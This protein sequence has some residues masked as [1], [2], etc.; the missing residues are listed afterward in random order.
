MK[1]KTERKN[2][3]FLYTCTAIYI[4]VAFIIYP[5]VIHNGLFDI[6][7]TKY[8]FYIFFSF[9]FIF[10]CLIYVVHTKN[11]KIILKVTL[12][13]IC[14]F[15]FMLINI[16]SF[17]CSSSKDISLYGS[18]G[19]MFGLMTII[20][21]CISC[22]FIS[23]LFIVSENTI[24]IICIGS[25]LV[26]LIGILNFCGIDPLQ[27]YRKMASY[28]KDVFIGTLGH[29]NIYSS[30]F[31]L[32][33]PICFVMFI[34]NT[35]HKP[36]YFFATIINFCGLISANSDSIFIALL[37]CVIMAFIFADKKEKI[38]NLFFLLTVLSITAKSYGIIYKITGNDRLVD[39]LT[40]LSIFNP[41][42]YIISGILLSFYILLK[43]YTGKYTKNIS[44]VFSIILLISGFIYLSKSGFTFLNFSD[45]W[46]NNRGFIWKTC[47]SLFNNH[48]SAKDLLIGC[49][50]DCIQPAIEQY[51]FNDIVFGNFER[52]NNAH[53]EPLQYLLVNG[54]LGL[55]SYIGILLSTI[56]KFKRR[57]KTPVT[58][59]L[60]VA[61]L[62]YF[63]Q[64]LFNINQIMTTPLFFIIIA[65]INSDN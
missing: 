52:F 65:L 9:I 43:T 56:Y 4:A 6:S 41:I 55:L 33:F 8:S 63:V 64:S 10:I 54:I 60:F 13:D 42:M 1:E 3:A 5:L 35:Q 24:F 44:S 31:S 36:F 58:T 7:K 23:K 49:G 53:N 38:I 27:I 18:S 30:F 50:P 29:C 39:S 14:L 57:D 59:A 37:M 46:G 25:C 45:K 21:M 40:S 11:Y 22:F 26:A 12:Y 32:A 47:L 51:Y 28:Q 61:M 2:N 62:C 20:P 19:R 34:N 17:I 48:Y 16:I 15:L